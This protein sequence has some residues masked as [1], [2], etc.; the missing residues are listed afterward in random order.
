MNKLEQ[1]KMK[2]LQDFEE[3]LRKI[4]EKISL[5]KQEMEQSH[6][7]QN[8]SK[9]SYDLTKLI[10]YSNKIKEDIE[11][12]KEAQLLYF[13]KN[14]NVL[15]LLIP[16]KNLIYHV[17]LHRHCHQEYTY[18]Y[19]K[20]CEIKG[21]SDEI[22]ADIKLLGAEVP[23]YSDG[24]LPKSNWYEALYYSICNE[25]PQ[26]IAE[27]ITIFNKPFQELESLANKFEILKNNRKEASQ[28]YNKLILK[29]NN[30]SS[31]QY[32]LSNSFIKLQKDIKIRE[33]TF[34]GI[35]GFFKK[36]L[37]TSDYSDLVRLKALSFNVENELSNLSK[38]VNQIEIDISTAKKYFDDASNKFEITC[39]SM[40]YQVARLA[41]ILRNAA[42]KKKEQLRNNSR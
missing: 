23:E 31:E 39:S 6:N 5:I 40:Q 24:L 12:L 11:I 42:N 41:I 10:D 33:Q 14:P 18:T 38:N 34:S 15:F 7:F 25:N 36:I 37:F 22:I 26:K 30:M 27:A 1:E 16:D 8:T 13:S 4:D 20:K 35:S 28:N 19:L 21:L 3:N 2:L 29:R 9:P 17:S 32:Q